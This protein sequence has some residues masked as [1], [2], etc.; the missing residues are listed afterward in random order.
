MRT[1]NDL[2][3]WL[4]Q[5]MTGSA[6]TAVAPF[7]RVLKEIRPDLRIV[8][9]RRPVADVVES[10]VRA[11][12]LADRAVLTADMEKIDR[13]L[14]QIQKRVPDALCVNFD[15]LTKEEVCAQVFEYCLPFQHDHSWWAH[16]SNL[17]LQMNLPALYRYI[18]ANINQLRLMVSFCQQE[19]LRILWR[20]RKMYDLDGMTF[21]EVSLEQFLDEGKKLISQHA[22]I[23]GDPADT[24]YHKNLPL[25][26]Q[27]DKMGALQTV[28]ARANGRMFGYLMSVISPS[29]EDATINCAAQTMFYRTP[30]TPGLGTRLQ[31]ASIDFLIARGGKW[32]ICQ[33]AG[34]K[35]SGPQLGRLFKRMGSEDH[36]QTFKL[37]VGSA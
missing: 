33:R 3:S 28:V 23:A 5:E 12:V 11:G 7:W 18:Y 26:F 29:L 9:V 15:D 14:D 32:E 19:S 13:K 20:R 21:H 17:N 37:S 10:L 16:L 24:I 4:S 30:D 31:R 22:T 25:W 2:R 36:G 35:A 8:I 1:L 34:V 6:E 27:L